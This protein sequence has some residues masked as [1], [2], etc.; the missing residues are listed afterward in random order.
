MLETA[1]LSL[2]TLTCGDPL[3]AVAFSSCPG[4]FPFLLSSRAGTKQGQ[5]FHSVDYEWRIRSPISLP[6]FS[7]SFTEA[8]YGCSATSRS[9][10]RD[11]NSTFQFCIFVRTF[12]KDTEGFHVFSSKISSLFPI[13]SDNVPMCWRIFH[14]AWVLVCSSSWNFSDTLSLSFR[15]FLGVPS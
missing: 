14:P 6:A 9:V 10:A 7:K 13:L 5:V 4:P 3:I 15:Q 12:E 2:G 11:S 8:R 1:S